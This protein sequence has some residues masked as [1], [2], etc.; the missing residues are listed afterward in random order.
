MHENVSADDAA[1]ALDEISR[2]TE[3]V[4]EKTLVPNW[5]WWAVAALNVGLTAA[6]ESGE[7]VVIGTGVT[8]FV[9]GI[10]GVAGSLA[11]KTLRHAQVRNT[12][13]GLRGA[14]A[15]AGFILGI[16]AVTLPTAFALEAADVPYAS[17]IAT[18]LAGVIMVI[19][20]PMLMKYVRRTMRTHGASRA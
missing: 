5:F 17:I 20:G 18:A 14:L 15:V 11:I 12:L 2:R 4:I 3:Q 13:L 7:P 9:L 10:S 19:G 6:V 1:R 16:A 8:L